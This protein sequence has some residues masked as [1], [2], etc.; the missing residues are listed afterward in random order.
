MRHVCKTGAF[1]LQAWRRSSSS[2]SPP[3]LTRRSQR[4]PRSSR[5]EARRRKGEQEME[6]CPMPWKAWPSTNHRLSHHLT[7]R[8]RQPIGRDAQGTHSTSSSSGSNEGKH[9]PA[10]PLT[11]EQ[12]QKSAIC[13]LLFFCFVFVKPFSSCW[14]IINNEM[15]RFVLFSFTVWNLSAALCWDQTCLSLSSN[16]THHFT[17]GNGFKGSQDLL[18]DSFVSLRL[19]HHISAAVNAPLKCQDI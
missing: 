1:R 14:G 5:A 16:L 8:P 15:K 17:C 7:R 11:N 18:I 4:R 19:H 2:W 12:P 13:S 6:A 9:P 10:P 3:P